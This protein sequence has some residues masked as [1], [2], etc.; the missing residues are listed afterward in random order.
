MEKGIIKIKPSG[1]GAFFNDN[2]PDGL[3]VDKKNT[4]KSLHLDSVTIE[5]FVNKK[6][7]K[8]GEVISVDERFKEEFVG[9]IRISNRYSFVIPDNNKIHVD[10]FVNKKDMLNANEGDKVVVKIGKWTGK[11]PNGKVVRVLGDST[12]NNTV[13]HSILEEFGLPYE[14][15]ENVIKESEE[16]SKEIT[17]Q[18]IAERRDMRN[19][20]TFTIDPDTAKDF[21]D[22]LSVEWINGNLQVGVHIADVSHY[23]KEGTELDKEAFKR[24]TSVYLVDR[25]V[26]M[27]PEILSNELCSLKPHED[28]LTYSAV[29]TLD[30][31]ANI[32]D[33]W[34]GRTIIHSDH[35]FTYEEAQEII[36]KYNESKLLINNSTE[37][38]SAVIS[39]DKYAKKLRAQRSK[40]DSISFNK[41]E[42]KFELDATGKPIGVKFKELKDSNKLIEEFM[43][44]ANKR[45]AYL[46]NSK[47]LTMIQ[48]SHD[49]PE[50]E[51]LLEL[52][53][54]VSKFGYT[55]NITDEKN[56]AKNM[57]KLM[58]ELKGTP[59]ENLI[60]N[61]MT[62]CMSKAFYST[63]NIGHF[64]LAFDDYSHFTSPI[65]R[66][67]DVIAHRILTKYLNGDKTL[68][69]AK[70]EGDA[71]HCSERERLS[72]KAQ[73]ASIKY[74]QAEF[75]SDRVNEVFRGVVGMVT[76]FGMFVELI[77]TGCEG[78][79][80]L[81]GK[82]SHYECDLNNFSFKNKLTGSEIRLGD[83]IMVTIKSVDMVRKEIE[84]D[85]L[86]K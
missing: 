59:E 2:Y 52:S 48:R 6:G 16:I 61:L 12:D 67:P 70:I 43:L 85:L 13:M 8:E 71:A 42:V 41:K 39:L 23:L 44:L 65:R 36:E 64:G 10:F 77:D 82:N 51:R 58:T 74:K 22:A 76:E 35:R 27:L 73:R 29:F 5:T 75:L 18:D 47:Q 69:T 24:A 72:Q 54:Y 28:K 83:E 84:L 14:F 15:P 53:N 1:V 17:E 50:Y 60:S 31:D 11:S 86:F 66:Y 56:L 20:L 45:V 37:L 25:C 49:R 30:K 38:E 78:L 19:V 80:R 62:R 81:G 40:D 63:K 68:T 55:L 3:F 57:N 79:V 33:E 9:T 34:F 7:G 21:D 46:I 32:I 4:G 26:P